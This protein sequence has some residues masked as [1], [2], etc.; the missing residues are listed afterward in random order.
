MLVEKATNILG[1]ETNAE[2]F[3]VT[4][5]SFRRCFLVSVGVGMADALSVAVLLSFCACPVLFCMI[6]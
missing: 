6:S 3:V 2:L 1:K 5:S 4:E